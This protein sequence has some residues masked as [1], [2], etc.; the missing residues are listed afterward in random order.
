MTSKLD[1]FWHKKTLLSF[2]AIICI[3]SIHN[4][5]TSQYAVQTDFL[6]QTTWFIRNFFSYGLGAIAV[7]CFFFLS[8]FTLFR[9]YQPKKYP[10][11]LRSRLHTLVFPYLLW[12]TVSLF[13]IILCTYTP[14][15]NF[16]S[17][18]ETFVPSFS[19]FI[20]G[21]FLYKYNFQFW[22]LYD[23]IFYVLLTPIIHLLLSR[24]SLGLI[25]C[26]G[27]LFL[28]LFSSSFLHLHLSFTVFYLLGCFCGKHYLRQFAKPTA[29]SSA[30]FC[31]LIAIC[32]LTLKCL[33]VYQVIT[34]P[35]ITS[36]IL[37]VC[38]LLSFWFAS[39][40]FLPKLKPL[41]FTREFFPIYILHTYF[42]A[43]IVKLIYLFGPENSAMLL[44]NEIFSTLF[45]IIITATLAVFWH[46]KLPRSYYLALGGKKPN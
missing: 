23:L 42:L 19:N 2:F 40:L 21:I 44:F 45:T 28:P 30:L 43:V 29:K 10:Q 16:I 22:F 11:K 41:R 8:G 36:Q 9:N 35:L 38:L 46:Q 17:G 26:L 24:K 6:T 20:E 25:A 14:I 3:V 5:A 12:N 7:P 13:F 1:Y 32:L 15:A 39:D 31:T 18:R 33:T 37:L 34:L 27:A 4:S